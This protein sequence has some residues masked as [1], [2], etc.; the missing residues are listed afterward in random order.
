MD[1]LTFKH[2]QIFW[3]EEKLKPEVI[4]YLKSCGLTV[5][6]RPV[7]IYRNIDIFSPGVTIIPLTTMTDEKRRNGVVLNIE[8]GVRSL[9]LCTEIRNVP[10]NSLTQ[11]IG[12]VSD[13]KMNE[14]DAT[15]AL[16]LGI[17]N[18]Y[19]SQFNNNIS[20]RKSYNY[21]WDIHE[22]N[23]RVIN[24]ETKENDTPKSWAMGIGNKTPYFAT[25]SEPQ[26]KNGHTKKVE[27]TPC[28]DRK[29]PYCISRGSDSFDIVELA[30]IKL[31]SIQE[32][33]DRYTCSPNTARRR[34]RLAN[35]RIPGLISTCNEIYDYFKT[36]H[37]TS[38]DVY[39]K[40]VFKCLNAGKLAS[41]LKMTVS[42]V[43]KH[44][45]STVR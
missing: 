43:I 22:Y 36:K 41:M 24:N 19:D 6:S 15:V 44:Q 35:E 37:I 39:E 28:E 27:K 2:G 13:A 8:E 45:N 11:F 23:T 12:F 32:I 1:K 20:V 25:P 42:E 14:I 33:M 40:R 29:Y 30:W 26:N 17:V 31:S 18:D 16:Y 9:A 5:G 7:I 4:D 38:L 34:N 21:K 3:Y 10:I